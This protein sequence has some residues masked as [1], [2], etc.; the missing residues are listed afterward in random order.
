MAQSDLVP[1]ASLRVSGVE[2]NDE[3]PYP[4][5]HHGAMAL[6]DQ[7]ENTEWNPPDDQNAW[8]TLDLAKGE[9]IPAVELDRVEIDWGDRWSSE[10]R[11]YGG[12]DVGTLRLLARDT[13]PSQDTLTLTPFRL[14]KN[15]RHVRVEF[16]QGAFA[17]RELRL[18]AKNAESLPASRETLSV[19]QTD[20]LVRLQVSAD[21][22]VHHHEMEIIRGENSLILPFVGTD[23]LWKTPQDA[24]CS[25]RVRAV[26]S[27][28]ES[29]DWSAS[30]TVE[31]LAENNME[32]EARFAV[33]EHHTGPLFSV[34]EQIALLHGAATLGFNQL[35]YGPM[36]DDK[37]STDWGTLYDDEE[38]EQSRLSEWLDAAKV[39]E[40]DPVFHLT[41][42][43]DLDP[44]SDE[45]FSTLTTKASQVFELGFTRILLS[46][47]NLEPT[48]EPL[49]TVI[50]ERHRA[51]ID[52]LQSWLSENNHQSLMVIPAVGAGIPGSLSENQTAYLQAISEADSAIL[53]AWGGG[54]TINESIRTGQVTT[55]QD[56]LQRPVMVLD[57]YPQLP[58]EEN[59]R[60]FFNAPANRDES[61]LAEAAGYGVNLSPH[62]ITNLF[63]LAESAEHFLK[64]DWNNQSAAG[65][66]CTLLGLDLDDDEQERLTDLF[67]YHPIITPDDENAETLRTLLNSAL[68]AYDL[69][70][71][72]VIEESFLALIEELAIY[73]RL[74]LHLQT[75]LASPAFRDA[76]ILPLESLESQLRRALHG[77]NLL[78][79][80]LYNQRMLYQ[81]EETAYE[82]ETA[83]V[84]ARPYPV[85][86]DAL[87]DLWQAVPDPGEARFDD[88][89]YLYPFLVPALSR[90]RSGQPWSY[91][92][93]YLHDNE[94][95]LYRIL[96]FDDAEEVSPNDLIAFTPPDAQIRRGILIGQCDKAVINRP[97][98][99]TPTQDLFPYQEPT[100]EPSSTLVDVEG[101]STLVQSGFLYPDPLSHSWS[102]SS[103]NG[104]WKKQRAILDQDLTLATRSD[105]TLEALELESGGAILPEFDDSDWQ[106]TT[107]PSPENLVPSAAHENGPER[108]FGGVWYRRETEL[109]QNTKALRLAILGASYVVDVWLDGLHLGCHEGGQTP[110][111]FALPK[112]LVGREKAVLTLR[113]D[114]P[115][116]LRYPGLLWRRNGSGPW[117]FMGVMRDIQW[118]YLPTG[119][120]VSMGQLR[121]HSTAE[122]QNRVQADIFLQSFSDQT[123]EGSVEIYVYELDHLSS[124]YNTYPDVS[125]I[126]SNQ[127]DVGNETQASFTLAPHGMTAIR[128]NTDILNAL[129][130]L[131]NIPRL[132]GVKVVAFDNEG[133]LLD[134]LTTQ[135]GVRRL[136]LH[137]D[138]AVQFNDVALFLPGLVVRE[139]RSRVVNDVWLD[140]L[141]EL[142]TIK[143]LGARLVHFPDGA[144]HPSAPYLT[145]R[146]GLTAMV[147][148]PD[149][150]GDT[151][152]LTAAY[153]RG[154]LD[155]SWRE[156]IFSNINHSSILFWSPGNYQNAEEKAVLDAL[157][158][159]YQ[160]HFPDGRWSLPAVDATLAKD[161]PS[162]LD[163][164]APIAQVTLPLEWTKD[165]YIEQTDEYLSTL[166][167]LHQDHPDTP[168]LLG[169]V[170]ALS[171]EVGRTDQALA[172]EHLWWADGLES[173]AT[174]DT[175][176]LSREEEGWLAGAL[177]NAWAD[178]YDAER[179]LCSSGILDA[180]RSS[181]KPVYQFVAEAFQYYRDDWVEEVEIPANKNDQGCSCRH[182]GYEAWPWLL[183]VAGWM[184]LRRRRTS[185]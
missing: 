89:D 173:M 45:D 22:T 21:E 15:V 71:E 51:F 84:S 181:R 128:L 95:C 179:G 27:N 52:K 48:D 120:S 127:V 62:G 49:T 156:T 40:I 50:G 112:E 162:L 111:Y 32:T 64:P 103:L 80:N 183:L 69:Q 167:S 92:A 28:G 102:K 82:T 4:D 30:S 2:F 37:R 1:G 165:Q 151:V 116:P 61:L 68:N 55:I 115:D 16:E 23:F 129:P 143:S 109:P 178:V 168:L 36:E 163:D 20:D 85:L 43:V 14:A 13:S 150:S 164:K 171:S 96:G 86:A 154:V 26:A 6:R 176:S 91:D 83:F 54:S 118:E 106:D 110:A 170:G 160:D 97:I 72:T 98:S 174:F 41:P 182:P 117:P 44:V 130:W 19:S 146:L 94:S 144:P 17:V 105:E 131:V 18:Y 77:I 88:R 101:L 126:L 10:V 76:F 122:T 159:D 74:A 73:D 57:S 113:V 166:N 153:Q 58:D 47:E 142:R 180:D 123:I 137:E 145:D 124:T 24:A 60:L 100:L 185:P 134:S 169:S 66:S 139:D 132:Y 157:T 11:L 104:S 161:D 38:G 133:P 121:I 79:A 81:S 5:R 136:A 31:A 152:S 140:R 3:S 158:D 149:L 175:D 42:S 114:A 12:P 7:N 34:T 56:F 9:T 65:I 147:S 148:L 75:A 8:I 46:L 53:F 35:I 107:L 39:M 25:F 99:L 93:G 63:A 135:F 119:K 70:S 184:I 78:T 138:G 59:P 108:Y 29:S 155:Q 33:W 177:W 172:F 90:T 87:S 141:Q 67:S 125:A